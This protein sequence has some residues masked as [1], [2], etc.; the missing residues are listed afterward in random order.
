MVAQAAFERLLQPNG[1]GLWARIT[2][3][4]SVWIRR[5]LIRR[6]DPDVTYLLEGGRVRMPLSHELPFYRIH[7]H[8]YGS[9]IGRIAAL[10]AGREPDMVFVDIGANV[11]DT[12]TFV[13]N[14]VRVPTLCI[15]G[16]PEFYRLLL[17][18]VGF[19]P[20]VTVVQALLDQTTGS[21]P[22]ALVSERGTAHFDPKESGTAVPVQSL[23]DL[24]ESYQLF[25]NPKFIKIDTDG[26]DARILTGSMALIARAKPIIFMEY[27][28]DLAAACGSDLRGL[29]HRLVG[30]G[31][32]HALVYENTGEYMYSLSLADADM[33]E[34]FHEFFAGRQGQRYADI[35]VFHHDDEALR[36]SIRQAELSHFRIARGR[37]RQP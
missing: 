23:P 28:P 6:G 37:E 33:V 29:L 19:L 9:G 10:I 22:G 34:D 20:D 17:S 16:N 24:L 31:Y 27:D 25:R 18:N 11:G 36:Q 7:H 14:R 15:E 8:E 30:V 2:R 26:M 32:E 21:L 12:A 5:E 13:R 4:A 3:R 1:R 35:C